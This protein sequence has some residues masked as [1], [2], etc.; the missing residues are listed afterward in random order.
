M[1]ELSGQ[2][3]FAGIVLSWSEAK[4]SV[5]VTEELFS[6]VVA[7][8]SGSCVSTCTSLCSVPTLLL[9][10]LSACL[11]VALG[12]VSEV[13]PDAA[14]GAECSL[15]LWCLRLGSPH[16]DLATSSESSSKFHASSS[17]GS[18]VTSN[19]TTWMASYRAIVIALSDALVF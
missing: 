10:P 6:K 2:R 15:L 18:V 13:G 12:D 19:Q 8:T 5:A 3:W 9:P 1:G 17:V 4:S 16:Q 14:F 11:S 7:S